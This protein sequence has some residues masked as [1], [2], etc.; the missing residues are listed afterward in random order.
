[1]LYK[2][3]VLNKRNEITDI[4]GLTKCINEEK[5]ELVI[6]LK[7]TYDTRLKTD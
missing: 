1:M 6:H 3:I 4:L 7:N 5:G 2:F